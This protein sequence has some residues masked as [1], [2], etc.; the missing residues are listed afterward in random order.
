MAEKRW[1]TREDSG[2]RLDAEG[3]FW[4]DDEPI[5]NANVSRAFHRGLKRAPDGKWIVTFGWDWAYIQ[6]DDAP[7]QVLGISLGDPIQL[8]LDDETEEPLDPAT[9]RASAEGVLYARVKHGGDARLSRAAQ[10]QLAPLLHERDGK[11]LLKLGERE[12][13]VENK[14]ISR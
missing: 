3:Q 12:F 2:I 8:R 13:P 6:V 9:L 10:G 4:H 1:H 14:D 7:Y 5:E 11:L